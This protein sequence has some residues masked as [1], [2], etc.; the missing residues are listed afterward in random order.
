MAGFSP[1]LVL[2]AGA[3]IRLPPAAPGAAGHGVEVRPV[4]GVLPPQ[5]PREDSRARQP[6]QD[7]AEN[8]GRAR[9]DV[10][11]AFAPA[12]SRLQPAPSFAP[13]EFASSQFLAQI[14]AQDLGPAGNVVALHR[15]GPSLSSDAYRQA[16]GEPVIYSEQPRILRIAV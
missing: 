5:P 15:D 9:R 13:G 16:G 7:L 10:H 8:R 14:I 6:R 1:P 2:Q 4:P 11:G 12:R 3:A